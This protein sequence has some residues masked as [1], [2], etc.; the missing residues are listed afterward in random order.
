MRLLSVLCTNA[1]SGMAHVEFMLRNLSEQTFRDFEIVLVDMFYDE[2]KNAVAD[3]CGVLGLQNIVHTPACEATHVGRWLHWELYSN[4]L[5]LASGRWVFHYGVN[6]YL[7]RNALQTVADNAQQGFSVVFAQRNVEESIETLLPRDMI[8]SSACESI[9]HMNVSVYPWQ[10]LS[11]SGFFSVESD[12][13]IHDFNGHN[14]ALV[15]HHWVDNDLGARSQHLTGK[16]RCKIAQ[17]GLL[18]LNKSRTG[19]YSGVRVGKPVCARE[20]NPICVAWLIDG[21]REDRRITGDVERVEHNGYSWVR[22]AV[23]GTIGVEDSPAYVARLS[24]NAAYTKA[25]VNIA[26]V[27][28]N[29]ETLAADLKSLTLQEKVETI[30]GSHTNARYLSV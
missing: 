5:L 14:E 7:H 4:A 12:V 28:R 3:L 30:S 15:I 11:Q 23:C 16:I 9:Y 25:P 20:A 21:L 19:G 26:G 27:G 29:I 8:Q 24:T 13:M 1:Y 18:R 17:N 10:Y 6:R 2:N 22:C